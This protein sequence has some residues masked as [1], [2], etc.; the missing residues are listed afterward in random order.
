MVESRRVSVAGSTVVHGAASASRRSRRSLAALL[1]ASAAIA[2]PGAAATLDFGG[3]ATNRTDLDVVPG[4]NYDFV[5]N[6]PLTLTLLGNYTFG[7][8]LRDGPGTLSLTTAGPG[9]LTL[10]GINTYSGITQIGIGT[11]RA[12][13]NGTLSPNSV[14]RPGS[15]TLDLNGTFQDVAGLTGPGTVANTAGGAAT[16]RF[17][18]P[19]GNRTYSGVIT[20]TGGVITVIKTG[21]GQQTLNGNNTYSGGTG[22]FQ[23][24][25][26]AGQ[27]GSLG[28]G[29]VRFSGNSVLQTTG[30]ATTFNNA[31]E[32]DPG[33]TG[34]IDTSGHSPVLT[35]LIFSA[36]TLAKIGTGSLEIDNTANA[37][38][39]GTIL[40]QGSLLLGGNDVLG[41]GNLT[42]TGNAQ[43][44]AVTSAV[45]SH[46]VIL[47]PIF[48][49]LTV[50]PDHRDRHRPPRRR[51]S[52]AP[53]ASTS[54][55]ARR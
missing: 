13:V 11:I 19:V 18:S 21:A 34:S 28:T 37:Y 5:Q 32:I 8:V 41:T 31:I 40:A 15:G 52:R 48:P 26:G 1:L 42:L 6:G 17:Q 30:S 7:G 12:G 2:V 20:E 3:V 53:A 45:F 35:G 43:V 14:V 39:G 50:Q 55:A 36:G 4:T 33:V 22:I 10:T 49:N 54:R 51:S 38:T 23:G 29:I 16:I 47:G 24:I 25:L 46:D 9:V 27:A 44:N